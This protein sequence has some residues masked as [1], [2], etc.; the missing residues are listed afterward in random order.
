M[1]VHST[2][3]SPNEAAEV[4]GDA[5]ILP[6]VVV[7][8]CIFLEPEA[9]SFFE[10]EGITCELTRHRVRLRAQVKL[11]DGATLHL[12]LQPVEVFGLR[13]TYHCDTPARAAEY[14]ADWP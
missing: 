6:G 13:W 10:Q 3:K 2:P 9:F 5:E 8:D 4:L 11:R 1:F 14:C 12:E 7:S